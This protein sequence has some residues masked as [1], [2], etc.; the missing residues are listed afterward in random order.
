M[1]CLDQ[2]GIRDEEEGK[3]E[4]RVEESKVIYFIKLF[5]F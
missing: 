4:W 3:K 1:L 5:Q 2:G